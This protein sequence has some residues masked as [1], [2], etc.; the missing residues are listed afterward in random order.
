MVE[1]PECG[2]KRPKQGV[3]D[4]AENPIAHWITED[5][6]CWLESLDPGPTGPLISV[7]QD[8]LIFFD[9]TLELY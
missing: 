4:M 9:Y 1:E 2:A 3:V 7:S 5:S 8:F 6:E